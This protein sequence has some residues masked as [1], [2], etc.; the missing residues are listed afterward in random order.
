MEV[1]KWENM[2]K[3]LHVLT[4]W[5]KHSGYPM[6][7][8]NRSRSSGAWRAVEVLM[9]SVGNGHRRSQTARVFHSPEEL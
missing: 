3:N 4:S 7:V 9:T 5:E 6:E 2:R 8:L 1:R